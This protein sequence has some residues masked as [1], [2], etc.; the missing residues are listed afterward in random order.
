MLTFRV[1][2]ALL[3]F[4]EDSAQVTIVPDLTR[5]AG[6]WLESWHNWQGLIAFLLLCAWMW[7]DSM[8]E[9]VEAA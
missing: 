4:I 9:K 8:K 7:W 5:I 3:R 2:S 1:L 6:P